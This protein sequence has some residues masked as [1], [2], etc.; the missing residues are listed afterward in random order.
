M[1]DAV[2][3]NPPWR[4][5]GLSPQARSKSPALEYALGDAARLA[6]S[7]GDEAVSGLAQVVRERRHVG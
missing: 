4:A 2:P 3:A 1:I 5:N 6:L 7:A